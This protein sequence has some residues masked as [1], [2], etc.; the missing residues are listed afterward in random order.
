MCPSPLPT[1]PGCQAFRL[2]Y[3]SNPSCVHL[4][5]RI[6]VFVY[7]MKISLHN[8]HVRGYNHPLI[9]QAERK[10]AEVKQLNMR[11]P[12]LAKS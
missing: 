5:L 11:L 7:V 9:L 8:L 10:A 4:T 1:K 3:P 2:N 6:P 12:K